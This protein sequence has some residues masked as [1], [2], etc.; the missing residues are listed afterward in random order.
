MTCFVRRTCRETHVRD[1]G[2]RSELPSRPVEEWDDKAAYVLLGPPGSGKTTVFEHEAERQGG[3]YVTA[4][5]FLTFDDKPGWRG[6]TLFIDGLDEARAGTADGRTPLDSIRAKLD[7]IGRPRFRL[8]CREADW[9]GGNDSEHLKTAAPDGAV[10]VLRLDS[11]SRHNIFQILGANLGV[12]DPADFIASAEG[13]GLQELLANPQSLKMLARAVGKDGVWPGTRTQTFEKACRVLLVE[14]NED[15]RIANPCRIGVPDLMDAAGRLCAVQLLTGAAGYSLSGEDSDLRF[16]G[17]DQVPGQDRAILQSCLGSKLFEAP[18]ECRVV[19]T[20]RVVAEFLAAR[21]LAALVRNG[22]PI[23]RI[24]ALITGHDGVTVSEL[25][26]LAAWLA[27][28][29]KS[30]RREIITRDPLGTVLYGDAKDFSPDEKCQLLDGLKRET[31]AN[32]RL[33]A[34]VQLDSRIGDLVSFDMEVQLRE[35]LTDPSREDSWQSFVVILLEA[36][37]HGEALPGLAGPLMTLMRDD[38]CWPRIRFGAMDAFVRHVRNDGEAFNELKALTADV[39]AGKVQDLDDALLGYLL[40]TLYPATIPET[41][42]MQYLRL[43]RRPNHWS[44]YN[45]FWTGH[46]SEEFDKRPTR[47]PS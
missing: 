37:Q 31:A 43:P 34:T 38:T 44:E 3:L 4:R 41:E 24:L 6:T 25:R 16:L 7:R 30:G 35:I 32:P 28:H 46:L 13:R 1:A 47:R 8:S 19:P 15:H 42:I 12:A 26:G 22:L 45:F 27:V 23:G 39:Y 9:F 18:T 33:I 10:T 29:S 14:H 36:L 5:D 11:L 20:H 21:Y 2:G 17:L 40:T